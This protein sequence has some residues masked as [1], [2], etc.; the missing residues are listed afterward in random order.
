M[1]FNFAL[2]LISSATLVKAIPSSLSNIAID[3][4]DFKENQIVQLN[5]EEG[6]NVFH[7][8]TKGKSFVVDR[9]FSFESQEPVELQITDFMLGNVNR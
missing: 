8:V 4:K 5:S 2:L 7:W 1:H 3:T 9:K 6:F